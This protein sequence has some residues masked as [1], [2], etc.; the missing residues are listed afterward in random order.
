MSKNLRLGLFIVS[1][2]LIFGIGVFWIGS[3]QFLFHST[4]QLRGEFKNVSGLIDGAMVRVG[5]INKG[6]VKRIDL[7]Q[8]PDGKVTVVMNLERATRGVIKKDSIAS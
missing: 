5:G 6:T 7:P 1:T 8:R 2:L 4:Y 3:Q